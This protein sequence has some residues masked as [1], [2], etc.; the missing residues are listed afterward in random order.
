[1]PGTF[2]G[3]VT[4][5]AG[6]HFAVC[7][8][9]LVPQYDGNGDEIAWMPEPFQWI[10]YDLA[11][12]NTCDDALFT[13]ELDRVHGVALDGDGGLYAVRSTRT[14]WYEEALGVEEVG[15]ADLQVYTVA[16]DGTMTPLVDLQ[17]VMSSAPMPIDGLGNISWRSQ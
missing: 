10:A 8:E 15:I 16:S 12:N 17:P 6:E 14:H 2:A 9:I 11:G 5:S 1:M 3:V 13:F 7:S 4:D